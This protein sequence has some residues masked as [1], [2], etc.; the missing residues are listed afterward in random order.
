MLSKFVTAYIDDSNLFPIFKDSNYV[1]QVL[2][3][4]CYRTNCTL[5]EKNVNSTN[6]KFNSWVVISTEGVLMETNEVITIKE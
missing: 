1:K 5:K 4:Y 2:K 6:I 3:K